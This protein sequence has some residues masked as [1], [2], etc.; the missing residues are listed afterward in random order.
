[1]PEEKITKEL[2][3]EE[4]DFLF[5]GCIEAEDFENI[6]SYYQM[7][8]E[9]KEEALKQA[10]EDKAKDIFNKVV[11]IIKRLKDRNTDFNMQTAF[12][13]CISILEVEKKKHL[14]EEK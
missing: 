7:M 3:E 1:M 12:Q 6:G 11:P 10:R 2:S 4:C 8:K 14:N 9:I 5:H 13:V